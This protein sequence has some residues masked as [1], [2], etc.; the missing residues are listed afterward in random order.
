MRLQTDPSVIY[1][2]VRRST[3]ICAA[4][5]SRRPE[6]NTYTATGFRRPDRDAGE[7]SI[8]AH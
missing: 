1:G 5:I 7:A 4:A 8:Q 3:A 6:Y 2:L